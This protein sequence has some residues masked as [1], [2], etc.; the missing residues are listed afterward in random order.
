MLGGAAPA[1]AVVAPPPPPA[2]AQATLPPAPLVPSQGAVPVVPPAPPLPAISSASAPSIPSPPPA[3]S[4]PP[5][6]RPSRVPRSVARVP[7]APE[8]TRTSEADGVSLSV[9]AAVVERAFDVVGRA[10]LREGRALDET[11]RRRLEQA[12]KD[13]VSRARTEDPAEIT[14]DFEARAIAEA[15]EGGALGALVRDPNVVEIVGAAGQSLTA[16]HHDGSLVEVVPTASDAALLFALRR[17][18]SDGGLPWSDGVGAFEGT[19][20]DGSTL[21][22]LSSP[23]AAA[24]TFSL[25]KRRWIAGDLGA[26]A[27]ATG[28][29]SSFGELAAACVHARA[30]LLVTAPTL[31]EGARL[32]AALASEFPRERTLVAGDTELPDLRALR[33]VIVVSAADDR[34]V[35]TALRFRAD[36]IVVVA[37][38]GASVAP[39]LEAITAGARGVVVVVV[40]PSLRQALARTSAQLSMANPGLTG[41]SAREIVAEAFDVAFE[42]SDVLSAQTRITRI[43]E[44]AGSDSKQ[45]LTRDLFSAVDFGGTDTRLAATGVVPRFLQ[46]FSA[47]GVRL[48]AG[49]FRRGS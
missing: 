37:P 48:D 11:T 47:R 32:V 25:A 17:L 40:A 49:L 20:R 38:G 42:L 26:F 31:A 23:L 29:G 33:D 39:V 36:R 15:L 2:A 46:D 3:M 30:N 5:E 6:P 34:V 44:V 7:R 19:L 4:L 28:L 8:P 14:P 43:A 18:A 9:L 1:S 12:V 21:A 27:Q 10:S 16:V 41:E 45:V 13:Q 22:A 35:Q 24:T